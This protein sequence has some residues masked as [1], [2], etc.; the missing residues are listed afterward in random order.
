MVQTE[1]PSESNDT[2]LRSLEGKI[3]VLE[4]RNKSI[5]NF[6]QQKIAQLKQLLSKQTETKQELIQ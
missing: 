6:Y 2:Y 1:L 3:L 4:E 5:Q